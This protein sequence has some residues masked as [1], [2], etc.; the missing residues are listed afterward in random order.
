MYKTGGKR[1][2]I[3]F[4]WG[5]RGASWIYRSR[6]DWMGLFIFPPYHGSSCLL[7]LPILQASLKLTLKMLETNT[8]SSSQ[9]RSWHWHEGKPWF[10]MNIA[11]VVIEKTVPQ[12]VRVHWRYWHNL[13]KKISKGMYIILLS[14]FTVRFVALRLCKTKFIHVFCILKNLIVPIGKLLNAYK[15]RCDFFFLG[16]LPLH[17]WNPDGK[18]GCM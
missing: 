1:F 18:W 12:I 11:E 13:K 14:C 3:F 6:L 8:D 5:G 10:H 9:S 7:V 16:G 15:T 4:Q 17:R 2:W